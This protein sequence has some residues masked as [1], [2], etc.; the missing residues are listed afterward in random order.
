MNFLVLLLLLGEVR[1]LAGEKRIVRWKNLQWQVA[2]LSRAD[3]SPLGAK[4]FIVIIM[5]SM[6]APFNQISCFTCFLSVDLCN[7]NRNIVSSNSVNTDIPFPISLSN[8]LKLLLLNTKYTKANCILTLHLANLCANLIFH[9]S[10]TRAGTQKV[11][12]YHTDRQT[13]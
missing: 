1:N 9:S 3:Q 7:M 13:F 6:A 8:M 5:I 11:S 12:V 10:S 2:L 4:F